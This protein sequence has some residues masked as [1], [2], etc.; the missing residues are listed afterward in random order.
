VTSG[1]VIN[2]IIAERAYTI[3]ER[4][5]RQ[6]GNDMSDWLQAEAEVLNEFLEANRNTHAARMQEWVRISYKLAKLY[7]LNEP[8]QMGCVTI[9]QQLSRFEEVL[10]GM[11]TAY[12]FR[13]LRGLPEQ[14]GDLNDILT[15]SYLWVLGAYEIVR[16]LAQET[17]SPPIVAAK[18]SFERIRV[19]LA[20]LEAS[21]KHRHIDFNFPLPT[22]A[23]TVSGIGWS[24]NQGQVI[25]RS[26]LSY[27]MLSALKQYANHA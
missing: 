18:E 19:P 7:P 4:R 13:R 1:E 15:Y 14:V 16:T 27:E 10:E 21:R 9:I 20:K 3:F 6:H 5:G 23:P 26:S 12:G 8:E 11:E 22:I 17:K 2:R 24:I 25:L